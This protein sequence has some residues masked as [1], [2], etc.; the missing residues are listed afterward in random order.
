MIAATAETARPVMTVAGIH[1][2]VELSDCLSAET[3][4]NLLYSQR[5]K[6]ENRF[7]VEHKSKTS[8]DYFVFKK[9]E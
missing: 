9:D 1:H 5:N 3:I 2:W 8:A 7:L 6:K 4:N